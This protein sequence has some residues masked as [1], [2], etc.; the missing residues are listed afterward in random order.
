MRF[1]IWENWEVDRR[2]NRAERRKP[3]QDAYRAER[4]NTTARREVQAPTPGASTAPGVQP[5]SELPEPSE[6]SEP[7]IPPVGES[8][9]DTALFLTIIFGLATVAAYLLQ[10]NGVLTVPWIPSSFGYAIMLVI[11]AWAF[12]KWNVP[13]R[14]RTWKRWTVFVVCLLGILILSLLGVTTQ[15]NREHLATPT[16]SPTIINVVSSDWS[17]TT[18]TVTNHIEEPWHDCDLL[19]HFDNSKVEYSLELLAGVGSDVMSYIFGFA[20]S[21]ERWPIATLAPK[22]SVVYRIK[23][24]LRDGAKE[25]TLRFSLSSGSSEFKGPRVMTHSSAGSMAAAQPKQATDSSIPHDST[26]DPL[27]P[28]HDPDPLLRISP[29][30]AEEAVKEMGIPP[31]MATEIMHDLVGEVPVAKLVP[32]GALKIFLGSSLGYT[33]KES[34]VVIRVAKENL[35]TIHRVD[36]SISVDAKI[37]G[38]D[39]KIIVEIENNKPFTDLQHKDYWRAERPDAQTLIIH[40]KYAD[41]IL[42]IKYLN[43]LAVRILGTF[44]YSGRELVVREDRMLLDRKPWG[45]GNIAGNLEGASLFNIN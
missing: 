12:R 42:S 30:N 35:L 16:V 43:P 27:K 19:V 13:L 34:Q 45:I 32:K 20:D 39:N 18:I 44:R 37:F 25:S 14:W 2:P 1:R 11:F 21:S 4:R 5:A 6:P 9:H 29:D 28:A 3:L 17:L 8:R 15:Y 41:K 23:Y 40:D 7:S 24:R 33:T 10:A 38:E 36:G 26:Y 31:E 22:G